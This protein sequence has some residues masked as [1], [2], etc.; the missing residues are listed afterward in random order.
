MKHS[1]KKPSAAKSASNSKV[2]KK[3]GL[4]KSKLLRQSQSKYMSEEQLEFFNDLLSRQHRDSNLVSGEFRARLKSEQEKLRAA[5]IADVASVREDVSLLE[6]M[7][8]REQNLLR[9]IELA[10]LAIEKREYGYCLETGKP[11]G[12]KRLLLSPTALYSVEA[13]ERLEKEKSNYE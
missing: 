2:I 11:I 8:N 7:I 12:L 1:V 13:K 5:D 6:R 4:T 10:M 3:S 9:K